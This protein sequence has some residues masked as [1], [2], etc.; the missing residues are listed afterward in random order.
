MNGHLILSY[1]WYFLV[2]CV[3]LGTGVAG[4]LY[5]RDRLLNEH[6]IIKPILFLFRTVLLSG[7]AFLLLGPIWKG[8]IS[9]TEK[10]IIIYL[11][12]ISQS[13]SDFTS[14]SDLE[15]YHNNREGLYEDLSANFEVE[16]YRFGAEL[17]A[18]ED[19]LPGIAT[20]SNI[21]SAINELLEMHSHQNVG[22][23]ILASDGI[24]NQGFNPSY[25]NLSSSTSIYTITLGDTTESRDIFIQALQYPKVVYLGDQFQLD[26]EWGAY[27]LQGSDAVL[28]VHDESSQEL[29]REDLNIDGDEVFGRES[30]VVDATH[31]GIQKINVS[32]STSAREDV[33][34]NNYSSAYVEVLDGRKNVLI[35]YHGAHPDV[36]ALKS[37]IDQNKNYEVK[38]SELSK[39]TAT[40]LI[41]DYDLVVFHGLP[42]TQNANSSSV[43]Q[44]CLDA[45]KSV[46]LILT[47][48]SDLSLINSSQDLLS[49][50]GAGGQSNEV[51]ALLNANFSDFQIPRGLVEAFL[52][53]PPL[54]TPFA[55]YETGLNATTIVWQRLDDIN[56]GYPLITYGRQDASRVMI[57]SGE[58]IWR[59]RMMEFSRKGSTVVFDNFINQLIQFVAIK[60]DKR[61]FRLMVNKNL[62]WENEAV[63]FNVELYNANYELINEVDVR[64]TITD[65]E[66]K[67]FDFSM[68]KT[69]N[70]YS[71]DAGLLPVGAYTA[72]ATSSSTEN[73][74]AIVKFNI[75][76][77]QLESLNRQANHKV[78]Y[79]LSASTGGKTH[80]STD[81]A[82]MRADIEQNVNLKP[83]LYNSER[84]TSL[85]EFQWIFFLLLG[86]MSLEW[87]V[88]KWLGGF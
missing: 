68:N 38:T 86:L 36:K 66:G 87:F 20:A 27:N 73:N 4:L 71:L 25:S 2:F 80:S 52:N 42:T 45:G 17:A 47:E 34:A 88:R 5:F 6:P 19:S 1:P 39:F 72:V 70:A 30:M 14:P 22:A 43:F 61:R 63:R 69:L 83:V 9:K 31:P 79:N 74:N 26:M 54:L 12:D 29:Y 3:L 85:L 49:I 40:D 55:E 84:A 75:R 59:W 64:L 53:Y 7:L 16:R 37:V 51:Q 15:V 44:D 33:A 8:I 62:V 65:S 82:T 50:T 67:T 10:P 58:G 56:T 11:E 78:L 23:L 32:I 41:D 81:M 57:L 24:Y 76:E 13:I 28:R 46:I 77:V 18:W 48:A 60:E 21:S 35:L